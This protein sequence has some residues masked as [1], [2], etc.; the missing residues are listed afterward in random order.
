MQLVQ[1]F[2]STHSCN[3]FCPPARSCGQLIVFFFHRLCFHVHPCSLNS[4]ALVLQ[5][6]AGRVCRMRRA[7]RPS[8]P[9]A[10]LELVLKARAFRVR[11]PC[12]ARRRRRRSRP[13]RRGRRAPSGCKI[14]QRALMLRTST[15]RQARF[16]RPRLWLQQSA[17]LHLRWWRAVAP[18]AARERQRPPTRK[19]G[20]EACCCTATPVRASWRQGSSRRGTA[21]WSWGG[22]CRPAPQQRQ[23]R[24][25]MRVSSSVFLSFTPWPQASPC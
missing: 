19:R 1:A 21:S 5:R 9:P 16:L 3:P 6:C 14:M 7:F 18:A 22:Q 15:C 24:A 12:R 2:Q 25:A 17:T 8:A 10:Q 13:L 20:W 23:A 4:C 11:Q